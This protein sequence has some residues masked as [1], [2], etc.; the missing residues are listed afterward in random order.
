MHLRRNF[1]ALYSGSAKLK[2][3]AK[4]GIWNNNGKLLCET[5]KCKIKLVILMSSKN[6]ITKKI[7]L[8]K[9]NEIKKQTLF[10][11]KYI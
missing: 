5:L 4:N 1:G 2:K 9:H 11:Y 3:G 10:T 6:R 7:T 8:V